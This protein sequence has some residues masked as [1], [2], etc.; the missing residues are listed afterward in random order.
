MANY[1]DTIEDI[2]EKLHKELKKANE[3]LDKNGEIN[4]RDAEYL[5]NML[6]AMKSAKTIKAMEE[7]SYRGGEDYS[8]MY[9]YPVYG[10]S[11]ADGGNMN[12]GSNT[13]GRG[14]NAK[15]DSMGHYSSEYGYSRADAMEDMAE[16]IRSA[17][18][19]MP[20]E[21]KRDAQRFLSKLEQHM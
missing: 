4:E 14:A 6:S 17:M 18:P 13:R 3:K 7:S 11:Y 19:S 20:E 12:G 16:D 9:P 21:L 15:R 10:R 8:G 2:C 5:R 1:L